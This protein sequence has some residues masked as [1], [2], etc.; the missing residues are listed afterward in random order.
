MFRLS[1]STLI[2]C[3][4]FAT[5]GPE[6]IRYNFQYLEQKA[7]GFEL[8]S[9]EKPA[10]PKSGFSGRRTQSA[11]HLDAVPEKVPSGNV[12]SLLRAKHNR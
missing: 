8:K 9:P 1:G 4:D 11:P 10:D 6:V 12:T 2:N 7:K 3:L 5:Q